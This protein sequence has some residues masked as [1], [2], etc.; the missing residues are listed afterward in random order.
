MIVNVAQE[1]G[2]DLADEELTRRIS[3]DLETIAEPQLE[4]DLSGCILDYP[5]TSAVIDGALRSL[6]QTETPR[7]LVIIFNIPF[8]ERIFIKWLFFG[9]DLLEEE[10]YDLDESVLRKRLN[11]RLGKR[12]VCFTVRIRDPLEQ[13]PSDT[14]SYG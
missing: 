4:I 14:Y 2:I 11:H 5:A 8:H 12:D 6:S 1:Y 13:T 7:S 10:E 9:G 3:K